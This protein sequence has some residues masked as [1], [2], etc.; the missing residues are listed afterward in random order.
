MPIAALRYARNDSRG[1]YSLDPDV[2]EAIPSLV[3]QGILPPEKAPLLLRIAGR[4]L[5][6]VY[7]EMRLLFYARG[8]LVTGSAGI[9]AKDNYARIGPLAT[10][11]M[12]GVA[13]AACFTWIARTAP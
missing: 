5:V 11:L 12:I 1:V 4:K 2:L 10:F 13:A 6:S 8:V 3:K 9:L 7:L